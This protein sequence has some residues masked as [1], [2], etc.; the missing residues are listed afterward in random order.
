MSQ[1]PELFPCPSC[2]KTGAILTLHRYGVRSFFC[3]DCEH[4][5]DEPLKETRP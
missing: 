1:I 5:W 4:V 3:P 2:K